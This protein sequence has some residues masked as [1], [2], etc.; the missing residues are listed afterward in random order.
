MCIINFDFLFLFNI[1]SLLFSNNCQE[2]KFLIKSNNEEE[3][4]TLEN[5]YIPLSNNILKDINDNKITIPLTKVN[6]CIVFDWNNVETFE[7]FLTIT[8]F[9]NLI[10]YL[11][12]GKV[13]KSTE[14]I[15][16][17]QYF[18]II[19]DTSYPMKFGLIKIKEEFIRDHIEKCKSFPLISK[20][21]G[22]MLFYNLLKYY[23]FDFTVK[24]NKLSKATCY[25]DTFQDCIKEN[26]KTT[27]D[28][29]QYII[30][31]TFK[32]DQYSYFSNVNYFVNQEIES[33]KK[34]V[35]HV[36]KFV[37]DNSLNSINVKF[38][39][40]CYTKF[41]I[42]SLVNK[43][44]VGKIIS[45]NLALLLQMV[46]IKHYLSRIAF[47]N[48]NETMQHILEHKV[49][50]VK[51]TKY[52][53]I[54]QI[55]LKDVLLFKNWDNVFLAGGAALH[56]Y[57]GNKIE[58][59]NDFDLFIYGLSEIDAYE[60][61]NQ[62]LSNY[63]SSIFIR[64]KYAITVIYNIKD[65]KK[66]VKIQIIL[67]LYSSPE[68]ILY[69]FDVDSCCIG[70]DM[71]S[72][73]FTKRFN[74][75]LNYMINTVDF[76]RM[77]PSYEYRLGKY[78]KK[79]FSI[80]IPDFEPN[81]VKHDVIEAVKRR[82]IVDEVMS[83][84]FRNLKHAVLCSNSKSHVRN[85]YS[86]NSKRLQAWYGKNFSIVN[87][88]KNYIKGIDLLL[89][90]KYIRDIYYVS[91]YTDSKI[92]DIN[93][94]YRKFKNLRHKIYFNK[95]REVVFKKKNMYAT[96]KVDNILSMKS[97]S[98]I[99]INHEL[100]WIT[101]NP[102]EQYTNTFHKTVLENKNVWYEGLFYKTK[103]ELYNLLQLDDYIRDLD[104]DD[105]LILNIVAKITPTIKKQIDFPEIS[106]PTITS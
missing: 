75:S 54:N 14:F 77:S 12:T 95:N 74:Y 56:L 90:N 7:S 64:S 35:K 82:L 34:Y 78:S 86:K 79:G 36:Q 32:V 55:T 65:L 58:D 8:N 31:T 25:V 53:W 48:R 72:F 50:K 99:E 85:I 59:I 80:Y 84:V 87:F 105:I 27:T 100:Q 21:V 98:N 26:I 37:G 57:L 39:E 63:T 15:Q 19:K 22:K 81:L 61:V 46:E 41:G 4:F 17:L 13:T 9:K 73:L 67:R 60:K 91:D 66:L 102:G 30:V 101:K 88:I 49:T 28:N 11:E 94:C 3:Q 6:D 47:I 24:K 29:M 10:T 20:E 70:C 76:D 45:P 1:V 51:I 33:F 103:R 97:E 92:E 68:E 104:E 69:G 43:Y 2:M 106:I 83:K 89:F 16:I 44:I 52:P 5:E 93:F 96:D 40:D 62:I 18:L 42:N 38:I 71:K 23:N